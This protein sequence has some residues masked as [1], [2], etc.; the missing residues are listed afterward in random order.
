MVNNRCESQTFFKQ[1][2]YIIFS[3]KFHSFIEKI[4]SRKSVIYRLPITNF[5]RKFRKLPDD[6]AV[7]VNFEP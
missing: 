4:G 2:R 7:P 5:Y 3:F 6:F 1:I